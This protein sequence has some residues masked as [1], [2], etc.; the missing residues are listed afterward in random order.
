MYESTASHRK[1]ACFVME[2]HSVKEGLFRKR[3][4]KVGAL[5]VS[6]SSYCAFRPSGWR[7]TIKKA[8]ELL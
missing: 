3:K 7:D 5:S 6:Y 2:A 8:R 1:E 4:G